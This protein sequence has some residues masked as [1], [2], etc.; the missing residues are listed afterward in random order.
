MSST[1]PPLHSAVQPYSLPDINESNKSLQAP[2]DRNL[3]EI[4]EDE[5][6]NSTSDVCYSDDEVGANHSAPT[7]V[8]KDAADF[9]EKRHKETGMTR[10]REPTEQYHGGW[11]DSFFI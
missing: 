4:S 1:S 6:A 7:D 9:D 10:S 3:P 11:K 2:V 8:E 5:C